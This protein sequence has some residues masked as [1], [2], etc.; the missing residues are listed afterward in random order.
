MHCL[1]LRN[2]L[3]VGPEMTQIRVNADSVTRCM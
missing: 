2:T 1:K 3:H